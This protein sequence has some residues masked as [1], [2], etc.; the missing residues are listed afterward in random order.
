MPREVPTK[1][2]IT[3]TTQEI[4]VSAGVMS[5]TVDEYGE[6]TGEFQDNMEEISKR[7]ISIIS[8][9]RREDGT[10]SNEVKGRDDR[11]QHAVTTEAIMTAVYNKSLADI[12]EEYGTPLGTAAWRSLKRSANFYP[13]ASEKH[14]RSDGGDGYAMCVLHL[15]GSPRHYITKD[16]DC[17]IEDTLETAAG[18]ATAKA[19]SVISL[20]KKLGKLQADNEQSYMDVVT[21]KL[22]EV[23]TAL[24]QL[25]IEAARKPTANAPVDATHDSSDD[26]E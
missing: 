8:G 5:E 10:F 1:R 4:K 18:K 16:K 20:A 25:A 26:D 15:H 12:R 21:E 3:N 13:Q 7:T 9:A 22:G 2:E 6:P 17:I 23:G 19:T 11:V 14:F 24:D